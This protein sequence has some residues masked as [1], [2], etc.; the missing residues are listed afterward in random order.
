MV[1]GLERIRQIMTLRAAVLSC[2]VL[3]VMGSGPLRAD[4]LS[5]PQSSADL[6]SGSF[7][8]P[9]SLSDLLNNLYIAWD[10]RLLAQPAFWS[11]P[12]L[13]K[14]FAAAKITHDPRIAQLDPHWTLDKALKD[15]N[16][17]L[18]VY[19]HIL[20]APIELHE[21][22]FRVDRGTASWVYHYPQHDEG[23]GSIQF[24]LPDAQGVKWA[25]IK[26]IF[27]YDAV[28]IPPLPLVSLVAPIGHGVKVAF[29]RTDF[30]KSEISLV[31]CYQSPASLPPSVMAD[32]EYDKACF[33]LKRT[34]TTNAPQQTNKVLIDVEDED[35][36]RYVRISQHRGHIPSFCYPLKI[37][38][39]L[40]HLCPPRPGSTRIRQSD[41]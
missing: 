20:P 22:H 15:R 26:H 25:D 30:W 5:S 13:E 37:D 14:M 24:E 19:T 31:A 17:S 12:S 23:Y 38:P 16:A 10:K 27:G 41:K 7:T 39:T 29:Y 33:F 1:S 18:A 21:S 2:F 34:L 36:V 32:S 35:I 3:S 4:H 9:S 8:Q 40:E 6:I 11:R 28:V